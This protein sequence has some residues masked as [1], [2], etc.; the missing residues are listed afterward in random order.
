MYEKKLS[1]II[2]TK[3][4]Q[5]YA[6]ECVKTILA[7]NEPGIE[8]VVQDNSDDESLRAMLGELID[9]KTLKYSYSSECL[10][11]C[12]NFEKAIELSSGDYLIMIGDDDC[13]FPEI[14]ALTDVLREK[15]IE[16]A[17]FNTDTSYMW[18]GA[19]SANG[20]RLVVRKQRSYIKKVSTST[21]IKRMMNV[22][23]YDYQGYA[24][25]KIY[26]GIIKRERFDLVKEKT[27]RY[28][29]GLTPDIYSAVALSYY[30]S[31]ILYVNAHF[32]LPGTCAKSG[33]ADSLT[34]RHTGELKDAPHFRGH[35]NYEWDETVPY[36]YTVDTIWAET[37]FKAM[38]EN[39]DSVE[40]SNKELF[41]FLTY[42]AKR[43][44]DFIDRL[45]QFYF[46]KTG[47]DRN[48]TAKRLA[49]AS[50]LLAKRAFVKKCWSFG[51]QLLRGRFVHEGVDDI[52][53]A[54][55]IVESSEKNRGRIIEKIKR[56]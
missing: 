35:S 52:S 26:H 4:R 11:F 24:F 9:Q 32:T 40:L 45:A 17:V 36:V 1:V 3:N 8:V 50:K 33:S 25:P 5:K 46:D 44:P 39:G 56:L 42:I 48:K 18:P 14:A 30:I 37:A 21:A 41:A 23:N 27:G 12:A 38:K 29:G 13:V 53:R 51:M 22:G 19:V 54:I 16:S 2:P 10:S 28:F 31:D 15:N 20:G 47:A 55:K 43:C 7:F 34:G 6:L 49:R